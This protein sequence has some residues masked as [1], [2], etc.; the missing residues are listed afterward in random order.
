VGNEVSLALDHALIDSLQYLIWREAKKKLDKFDVVKKVTE[1]QS[2][3][4]Q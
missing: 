2:Y 1:G 4:N 3:N